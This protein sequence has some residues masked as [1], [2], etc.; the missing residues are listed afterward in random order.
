MLSALVFG[1]ALAACWP[2]AALRWTRPGMPTA[3]YRGTGP[4]LA[5][6]ASKCSARINACLLN[7]DCRTIMA[8]S[9]KCRMDRP[10]LLLHLRSDVRDR[11]CGVPG[12]RGLYRGQ[13]LHPEI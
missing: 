9:S 4:Q 12:P 2:T 10:L 8:C 5:C 3:P 6:M 1:W 13:R 11:L 7:A